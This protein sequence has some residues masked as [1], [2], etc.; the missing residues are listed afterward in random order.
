MR[1]IRILC[2]NDNRVYRELITPHKVGREAA[3]LHMDLHLTPPHLYEGMLNILIRLG[4]IYHQVMG[5]EK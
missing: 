1:I 4:T 3:M 2:D 5:M